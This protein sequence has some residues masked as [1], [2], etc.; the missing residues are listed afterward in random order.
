MLR[1]FS[2]FVLKGAVINEV[3]GEIGGRMG[4]GRF[5]SVE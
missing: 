5:G 3:R 4:L 1:N 2:F